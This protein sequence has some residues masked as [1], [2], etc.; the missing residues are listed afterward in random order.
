MTPAPEEWLGSGSDSLHQVQMYQAA[1]VAAFDNA[2]S[3][4]RDGRQLFRARS[5]GRAAALAVIGQ[6]E[7]GK[8]VVFFLLTLGRIRSDAVDDL[9]ALLRRDHRSKQVLALIP[10]LIGEVARKVRPMVRD[11]RIP[12]EARLDDI[13]DALMA[14]MP[15][16]VKEVES[17]VTTVDVEAETHS[18]QERRA[19]EALKHRGLYVDS[20]PTGALSV[21][22]AVKRKEADEALSSLWWALR[23]I[24]FLAP[25]AQFPPEAL[26]IIRGWIQDPGFMEQL[27]PPAS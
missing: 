5:W 9:L 25:L 13:K 2:K 21:P 20:G 19:L 27:E 15:D 18:I 14:I 10:R 26:A 4:H 23:G 22:R 6:E 11:V 24:S 3:L 16:L 12:R 1:L 17:L 8:A 7:A